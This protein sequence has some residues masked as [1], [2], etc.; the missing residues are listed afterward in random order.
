LSE[1]PRPAL[2]LDTNVALDWLL[3]DDPSAAPL[4]AVI[5]QRQVRWVA[6]LAM[7]NEFAEVLRRGLAARCNANPATLL[8]AWDA[9][10]Q[11][12]AEPARPPASVALHCSDP[13]DQKFLD[14]AHAAG[15]AWLLSRDRAVL[16]LARRAARFGIGICVPERWTLGA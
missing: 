7:R 11:I 4:A 15:A 5:V 13:D 10:A 2:V 6:T 8:A 12:L 16:R 14:L 3:F 1:L 9:H